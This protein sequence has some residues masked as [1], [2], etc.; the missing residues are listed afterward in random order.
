MECEGAGRGTEDM[1]Q[2]QSGRDPR[3]MGEDASFSFPFFPPR[4]PVL[5]RGGWGERGALAWKGKELK[6]LESTLGLYHSLQLQLFR[7][8]V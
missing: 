7:G 1:G 4:N 5:V 3:W 6:C 8:T 2:G